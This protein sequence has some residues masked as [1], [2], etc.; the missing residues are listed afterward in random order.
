MEQMAAATPVHRAF[1]ENVR[2]RR[3]Q[4]GL[5]QEAV[6]EMLGIS[7]PTYAG[8]EAGRRVPGLDVV[9]RVAEALE[10]APALLLAPLRKSAVPAKL[11]S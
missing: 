5:T 8:I 2:D 10:I 11:A 9:E 7:Q 6:A 3:K 4:L 1:C